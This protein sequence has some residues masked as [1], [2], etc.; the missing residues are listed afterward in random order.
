MACGTP[1]INTQ[2]DTGVPFVSRNGISGL[3]VHPKDSAALQGAIRSLLDNGDLRERFG[4]AARQLVLR[5]F[6]ARRMAEETFRVYEQ[7]SERG[8]SITPSELIHSDRLEK[9]ATS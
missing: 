7:V 5:E 6:T 8:D 9:T 1:V 2:L 3:T 4:G